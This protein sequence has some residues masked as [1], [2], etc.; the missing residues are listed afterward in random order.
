M[1]NIRRTLLV[2]ALGLLALA[3]WR[4][5]DRP[6]RVAAQPQPQPTATRAQW[7]WFNEPTPTTPATRYFRKV[8]TIDR[9]IENPVDEGILDLTA[10]DRFT[11]WVNGAEVGKGDDW[12]RVRAFDVRK[13]LVHGP[14]VIAV[15]VKH[16]G[17]GPAGLLGRLGYVPNG[18]SKLAVYSGGSWKASKT[19]AAGW[20]QVDF[21]DKGWSAVKVLGPYGSAGPA[22]ELT[23]ET[24]GDDRFSVPA[25]FRVE[26]AVRIPDSD[27]R[28]S[29]VNVTFDDRGRLLVSREGGPV[30]ICTDPDRNGVLQTV[31][32]YCEVVRNCQGMCWVKDALLLVGDG[33]KGT[34]LY[35]VRDTDGGGKANAAT[36]LHQ[37]RGGMGEHGPHAIIHGPDD[38]LYLVLG[39][40]AWAQLGPE[41]AKNG[42][43][44]AKLAANSPLT[45][46]PKGLMGPDQDKPGTT[47]DV[48]LPRLNDARGH[49]ANILAPG[50][51]IWRLDHQGKNMSLVAA[52][53]RNHYD[54]AFSP[55]G[56]LF[57]F[58][59]DMEWDE[60]LPWYR[61]VRVCHCAPGADFVWR[62]GAANTPDYYLDSLPPTAETGRGSPVGVEFYDHTAFPEKYRGAFFMADWA[63]GVIFAVH[64]E[65]DGASYK[66][67]VERF[68]SGAPMNVTDLAV[69]PDGAL[70]FTMGGRGTQGGVYRI[71]ATKPGPANPRVQLLSAWSR[72]RIEAARDKLKGENFRRFL[73]KVAVG[74]G[75][76]TTTQERLQA[77]TILQNHGMAPDAALALKLAKDKDADIRAHALWLVGVNRY[78]QGD[79]AL[80]KGLKDG[81]ALVRRRACEALIRAGIEPPVAS[82]WPLLGDRDRFVRHAARLVVE[83]IDPKK[84]AERIGKEPND[85]IAWNGVIALCHAGKA[86]PHAETIFGRLH[87]TRGFKGETAQELLDYLRTVQLAL[88]HAGRRPIWMQ[89]IARQCEKLFP[90]KDWRVNREL[91]ILLTALQREGQLGPVQGK[92]IA[93]LAAAKG[94]RPQQIHYAYC[95][96]LL[97]D[98]WTSEQKAR[99]A[100]WYEGTKTWSGGHSF[101]PFLEN[102]FREALA[103]YTVADRREILR[104]AEQKPLTALVL[105]Q[106]LQTDGQPELLPDLRA[107]AARLAG[108][109][110]AHRGAELRQAVDAALMRTVVRHPSPA[111]WPLLM[112]SLRSKNPLVR[113]EAL[114]GLRKLETKPKAE[115]AA[116]YRAVLQAASALKGPEPRWEAVLLLRQWTGRT[117][118]GTV[119]TADKELRTW[120]RWFGQTFPKEA[121]L[122]NIDR[123]KEP[124]SKYRYADLLAYLDRGEGVKGDAARGR[125]VFE[126][127]QCSKCHKFGKVGEGVGPDLTALS[128]RFKRADTLEATYYPSKVISDQYRSTTVITKGGQQLTGLAAVQGDTVTVLLRDATQISL[129]RDEIDSQVAS[130][131]SVM[132]DRLLDTLSLR[133]IADLFAFLESEPKE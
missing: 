71:V 93:A 19:A 76:D 83:R 74:V 22:K 85:L 81:D 72:A 46:W 88:I 109:Q 26:Q 35:R 63:I 78:K 90:H 56:E 13:Y 95:L 60:G 54:A 7:V 17:T 28:F 104:S 96:R 44:P 8:F 69:G 94:D 61:A 107:L 105:A 66:A 75:P 40:H 98:G 12:K 30:L 133:E 41:V 25:G 132:P 1:T 3:G 23:W 20:Q 127:A 115:D 121:P 38:W 65:R 59:S 116:P 73:R 68:C 120:A 32:P 11:V 131:I 67:K 82:I 42:A 10:T 24:G 48:L 47:E 53:F 108:K 103:A 16:D 14:N 101:T 86:A 18:M 5:A 97:K 128:K 36:L 33:P 62:T 55:R 129:K 119:K 92:L 4:L 77:L 21:K 87:G 79:D 29:L 15:A 34:G 58:D 2:T 125:L 114:A 50:G 110:P 100:E 31:K 111:D 52:G 130:L 118:G 39:N 99:L 45:R 43:N 113:G 124:P 51:T 123:D 49:A 70:Y 122:P 102:I 27:A 9:P 106:R 6:G 91:A 37:F 89:G 57:T 126:K 64:L 112:E 117:F 80:L 84:Y